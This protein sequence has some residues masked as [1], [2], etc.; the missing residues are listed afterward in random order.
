ML[1]RAE[2][3]MIN[4]KPSRSDELKVLRAIELLRNAHPDMVKLFMEGRCYAFSRFLSVLVDDECEIH[5]SH[6]EGHVYLFW[7]NLWWDIRGA[8][9]S[10]PS[11]TQ[12]L[13]DDGHPVFLWEAGD[14]RRLLNIN[15]PH[16]LSKSISSPLAREYTLSN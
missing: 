10:V 9:N 15:E 4:A 5:Y 2:K 12:R 8:H 14:T 16:P 13:D 1:L 11:D 3:E 7:K 6:T